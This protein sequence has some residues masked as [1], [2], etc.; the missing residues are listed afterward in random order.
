MLHVH[1][2]AKYPTIRMHETKKRRLAQQRLHHSDAPSCSTPL[3]QHSTTES[4][5]KPSAVTARQGKLNPLST[6]IIANC[7]RVR[8]TATLSLCAK[9]TAMTAVSKPTCPASGFEV[10]GAPAAEDTI[11]VL[12]T[13]VTIDA[14]GPGSKPSQQRWHTA[15]KDTHWTLEDWSRRRRTL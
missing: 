11:I 15:S 7:L 3:P 5:G 4:A 2:T 13:I 12:D 1:G 8:A 6:D 9:M 14:A 10:M